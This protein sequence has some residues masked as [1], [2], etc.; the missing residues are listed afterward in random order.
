MARQQKLKMDGGPGE[1]K[2]KVGTSTGLK[3]KR[4]EPS[5]P[6]KSKPVIDL[7]ADTPPSKKKAKSSPKKSDTTEKRLKR[8]R[9]HAPMNYLDRLHRA[10][11][12]RMFVIDRTPA[13][14]IE[15]SE[16]KVQLAG[17][18]GNVYTV[19]ICQTP[20][21]NC[22]DAQKGNQCKHI[23][24]VMHF[25]LKA[26]DHLQYQLALLSTELQEIFAAAPSPITSATSGE[27][28]DGVKRRPVEGDC[29]ICFTAFEPET[30]EIVYCKAACGNNIHSDC[31]E[32]WARSQAGKEVKCVYCRSLWQG[33]EEKVMR[34]VKN[35]VSG[36][37]RKN[38]EGYVNVGAEL[39]LSGARGRILETLCDFGFRVGCEIL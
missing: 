36:Q 37:Q 19:H 27:T 34:I 35:K 30:E 26:P 33:D 20:S 24:Y 6:S 25:V 29:P 10:Q 2:A 15:S 23:I 5:T 39:G 7:T 28:E 22:P 21:C 38:G 1:A 31:F 17:T 12:Q 16:E 11:T 14:F 32:Q 18:T 4:I 13:G 3:R 9:D 8:F